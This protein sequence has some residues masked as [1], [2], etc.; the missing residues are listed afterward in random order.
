ME[1]ANSKGPGELLNWNAIQK[2]KYSWCVVYEA[3][4]LSPPGQGG[5][6]E[7]IT[8][9]SYAGFTIPKEWKAIFT[10]F[11][12]EKVIQYEKIM[13]K[14]IPIPAYGLPIHLHPLNN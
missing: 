8:D 9:F 10:I 4:R 7:A 6:R 11:K 1:I 13:Y 14:L 3:M 2:M 12:W 5:F